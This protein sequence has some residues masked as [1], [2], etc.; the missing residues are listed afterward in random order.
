[1]EGITNKEEKI[2]FTIE[3]DLFTLGTIT[4]L[5]LE[6]FNVIIFNAEANT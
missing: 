3:L 1:M 4:L 6:I 2:F 5:K